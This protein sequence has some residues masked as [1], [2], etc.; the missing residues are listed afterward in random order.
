[1]KKA[2]SISNILYD[3][4][5][6]ITQPQGE[7]LPFVIM[8]HGTGSDK[9][10]VGN[11]YADLAD[12]LAER[13]IA[14][15]RF[16]FAGCGDS[17]DSGINQTFMN[18][19]SDT[20]KIYDYICGLENTDREKIAVIGF[21]QGGR[22][23]AQFLDTHHDKIAA[24]VSWSGACHNGI[25]VFQG[26]FDLLYPQAQRKGWAGIPMDWREPMIIPL[27]WFEDIK[28]TN[29]L[30]ALKKFKGE[31]LVMAG[32][33]DEL[34][35]CSHANEIAATNEKSLC[36]TYDDADHTFNV[37]SDDKSIAQDVLLTTADW[38]YERLCGEK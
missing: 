22:V 24:A 4:P 33:K 10:E 5:A 30:D 19:V 23:M 31:L 7:K 27:G 25:G 21:S 17:S 20:V 8:C 6:V 28:N 12:L 37:L 32:A 14:S 38:L 11:M 18:E 3:I 13:G 16:D 1:M 9:N 26:W 36:I 2:V 15:A 29:P 34:V 35:P